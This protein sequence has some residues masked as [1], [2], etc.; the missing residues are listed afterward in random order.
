VDRLNI[1][2][3][4]TSGA[5]GGP[6]AIERAVLVCDIEIL[7]LHYAETLRRGARLP[8]RREEAAAYTTSASSTME[9]YLR[10]PK[11]RS[12]ANLMNFQISSPAQARCR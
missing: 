12:Q 2:P 7:R 5:V 10:R 9:F 6:S 1:F 11:W 8:A 3:A 4:A